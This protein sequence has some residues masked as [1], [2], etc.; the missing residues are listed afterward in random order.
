M[1]FDL[2]KNPNLVKGIE[3]Y[4]TE[5]DID[6]LAVTTHKRNLITSLLKPSITKELV[7]EINIPLLVFHSASN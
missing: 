4:I 1:K 7:F 6:I 2:I 3:K 5:K